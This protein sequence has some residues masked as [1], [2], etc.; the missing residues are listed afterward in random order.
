MNLPPL[1]STRFRCLTATVF[2]AGLL[3]GLLSAPPMAMAQPG[4]AGTT[5]EVQSQTPDSAREDDSGDEPE[6][7][8]EAR[9]RIHV[10]PE[11]GDIEVEKLAAPLVEPVTDDTE[12]A[13]PDG[14]TQGIL[15]VLER[16]RLAS[17]WQGNTL[18]QWGFLLGAIFVGLLTGKLVAYVLRRVGSGWEQR[19]WHAQGL[20]FSA[21][22]SPANLACISAGLAAGLAPLYLT[23]PLRDFSTSVILLLLL[24]A[25]FWYAYNLISVFELVLKRVTSHTDS[26]LDDQVL[27]LIRKSLR[28]FLVVVAVLVILETVFGA[29]VGTALAGLGIAGL[30]VSMAAQDS[31]KNLFGSI[32]I[33][34]DQPFQ[35]GERVII[36]GYDGTVEEIGF[37]STKIRTLVGHLVNIPNSV[38]VNESVENVARRPTIRRLMN[39]TITYDTPREK[40]AEAVAIIRELL[41]SPDFREPIHPVVNGDELPPRVYFNDFNSE[42]LNIIV[43]YWYAPT[44]WWAYMEHAQ[45]FNLALFE[46]FE[47]ADIEFAFPSQTLY[48]AGDAKRELA[49]KMLGADLHGNGNTE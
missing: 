33:L 44:D 36:S 4:A 3:A 16:M 20:V 40:I 17:I 22:A 31:L 38:I 18:Q 13:Q 39:V 47:E 11:T 28:L 12:A 15:Q 2:V 10:D 14:I 43:L 41:D 48:L 32:T 19:G 7:R 8:P 5:G 46:R 37:R 9:V 1:R 30:A 6:V 42:S 35:V 34:F 27:P 29:D 26:K 45:R 23:E 49:V 21:A 24:I 25:G